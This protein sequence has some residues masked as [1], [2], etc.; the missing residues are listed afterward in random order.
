MKMPGFR[1]NILW[2]KII[3]SI[4]YL[5]ILL[6]FLGEF[7]SILLYNTSIIYWLHVAVFWLL[8]GYIMFWL[9]KELPYQQTSRK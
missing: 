8:F 5:W 1:T 4:Y 2:K 3:S 7:L 9:M 6:I